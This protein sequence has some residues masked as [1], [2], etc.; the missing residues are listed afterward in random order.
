MAKTTVHSAAVPGDEG[1]A[2]PRL[3]GTTDA[4]FVLGRVQAGLWRRDWKVCWTERETSGETEVGGR[5]W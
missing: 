3:W 1:G 5:T 2:M 4:R